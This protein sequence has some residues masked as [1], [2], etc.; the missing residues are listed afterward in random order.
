MASEEAIAKEIEEG[1]EAEQTPAADGEGATKGGKKGKRANK[2]TGVKRTVGKVSKPR[3]PYA[4]LTAEV[5][6]Q[7]QAQLREKISVANAQV[8]IMSSKL[9]KYDD[10]AAFREQDEEEPASSS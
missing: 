9:Q 2:A 6:A 10:E 8:T 5:L 1:M 4:R 7:R 3:R